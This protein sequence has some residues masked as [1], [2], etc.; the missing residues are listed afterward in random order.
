MSL[1]PE[2]WRELDEAE[3]GWRWFGRSRL[4]FMELLCE[5]ARALID[6]A[7]PK[8]ESCAGFGQVGGGCICDDPGCNVAPCVPCNG[9][10]WA[11]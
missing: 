7:R 5:H 10:G 2:Q 3:R 8:C 11:Q 6:A 4:V 1:T 9:T